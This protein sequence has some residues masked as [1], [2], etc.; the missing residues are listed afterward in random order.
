MYS[1]HS[2]LNTY[3]GSVFLLPKGKPRP[4]AFTAFLFLSLSI[5]NGLY[6]P[7]L[8]LLGAYKYFL[9]WNINSMLS[10]EAS[11]VKGQQSVLLT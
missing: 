10:S 9:E 11:S 4:P 6:K 2:S 1:L 5:L 3:E 7:C 8:Q